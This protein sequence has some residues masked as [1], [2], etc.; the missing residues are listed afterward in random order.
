MTEKSRIIIGR[1]SKTTMEIKEAQNEEGV[2]EE[3]MQQRS[4]R[5]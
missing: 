4:P 3:K 5:D 2:E 1:G